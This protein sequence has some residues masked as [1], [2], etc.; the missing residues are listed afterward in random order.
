MNAQMET[1]MQKL[2]AMFVKPETIMEHK[3][4]HGSLKSLDISLENQKPDESLSV[5]MVTKAKL[6]KLLEEGD[7]DI[8]SVDK[9]YDGVRAFYSTAF[10][11]CTKWLPLNNTLLKHCVFVDFMQRNACSM[12][13]VEQILSAL[14]H[15]HKDMVNDPRAMDILEEEFLVYQTM[16]ETDIPAHIWEES[17]VTEK[18]DLDSDEVLTYHR[19][20]MIWGYLR[21]KLP[22]LSKVALSV[23]T[24]PH[25]NAAEELVFSLIRK[26]KTD[27][28]SN[29]DLETSLSSIMTIKMNKP[30]SLLPCH[31]FKPSK[32]LLKKCKAACREY[33]RAHTAQGNADNS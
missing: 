4:V 21:D 13:N 12:D 19:M 11:Y 27:F 17:A 29:L 22:N 8:Q 20:D 3:Q 23:L 7:I 5:G 16:S 25:S 28:R 31:R 2:A 10:A 9:F 6:R 32:E 15:I 18:Q 24:V 26:N 30:A 1:F 33:N 14:N